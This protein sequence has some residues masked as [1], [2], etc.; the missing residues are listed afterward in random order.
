MRLTLSRSSDVR[1]ARDIRENQALNR[2]FCCATDRRSN[3][4]GKIGSID[5]DATQQILRSILDQS[6][7]LST[8][9]RTS[10]EVIEIVHPLICGVI[11]TLSSSFQR[12]V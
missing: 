6:T 3:S 2:R 7:K 12:P 9:S 1:Q 8:S 4:N 5:A 10:D 11:V